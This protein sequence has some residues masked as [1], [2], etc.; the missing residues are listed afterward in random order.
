MKHAEVGEIWLLPYK[1]YSNALTW[2]RSGSGVGVGTPALHRR[3]GAGL[4]PPARADRLLAGSG[5]DE[6]RPMAEGNAG[7]AANRKLSAFLRAGTGTS[8][9]SVD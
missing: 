4:V 5:D 2:L 3:G 7:P 6:R 8:A 1:H 9:F